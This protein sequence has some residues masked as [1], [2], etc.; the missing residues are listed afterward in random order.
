MTKRLLTLSLV[1]AFCGLAL[2]G[3]GRKGPLEPPPSSII[4]NANG[5][6]VQKPREDK[7][8]ILDGLIK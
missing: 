3:C 5:E 1:T 7:P 4:E 6:K 2:A 8:F